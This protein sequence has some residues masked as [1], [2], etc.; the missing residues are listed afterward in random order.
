MEQPPPHYQ[1]RASD[2]E[3]MVRRSDDQQGERRVERRTER[4]GEHRSDERRTDKRRTEHANSADVKSTSR[5]ASLLAIR[6][7]IPIEYRVA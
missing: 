4:R 2:R 5:T 3:P 6:Y 1:R 7:G